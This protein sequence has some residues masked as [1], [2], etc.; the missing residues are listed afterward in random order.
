MVRVHSFWSTFY[1][2]IKRVSITICPGDEK[3]G[4]LRKLRNERKLE[5]SAHNFEC[6]QGSC[7][8]FKCYLFYDSEGKTE[9]SCAVSSGAR[10]ELKVCRKDRGKPSNKRDF[11]VVVVSY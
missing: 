1:E 5:Y 6:T 11:L 3:D 8:P 10:Y 4:L 9:K 7:C 2:P